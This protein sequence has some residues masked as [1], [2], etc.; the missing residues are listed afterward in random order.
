MRATRLVLMLLAT[1]AMPR[2]FGYAFA[3]GVLEI[4]EGT[5]SK[6]KLVWAADGSV[7]NGIVSYYRHT[8]ILPV[9]PVKA[10][11]D[12]YLDDDGTVYVNGTQ[13]ERAGDVAS[14]LHAGT[15]TIAICLV[16]DFY[17]SAAIYMVSCEDASGTR[18]Y[19]HSGPAVR[20]TVKEPKAGWERPDFNDSAWPRVKIC[21][22][23]LGKPWSLN[24][25]L[26]RRF[27]TPEEYASLME[28]E[29]STRVLPEGL[30]S[31]PDP[32]ARVL[33]RG[34]Q[35]KIEI[36]G[37]MYD[38]VVNR[39][40]PG[41]AY[42]DSA[43]VRFGEAGFKIVELDLGMENFYNGDGEPCIFTEVDNAVRRVLSLNPGA[44]LMLGLRFGMREWAMRNPTEQVGYATGPADPKSDDDR[45]GRP[46][47]PSMASDKFRE[48][49]LQMIRELAE[50]VNKQ[51]W[52]KRVIG[53]RPMCG[54]YGEWHCYG[55]FEAP[56]TGLRMQE[57]FRAYMQ[58]KRGIS[59]AKIPT[60]A[61]RRHD[62]CDLLDPAEDRLVLDYYDCHANVTADLLLAIAGE[63]RR[64]FPGRLVGAFYG[65]LFT[66]DAP[67]GTNVLLDKVLSSPDIDFLSSP[68]FHAACARLSGASYVPR[69]I[70]SAFRR[71]DKILLVEDDSRFHHIYRW[72]KNSGQ[73]Y[74]TR[75]ERETEMNMRR[76]WLNQ[77]FDCAGIQLYDPMEGVGQRAHAFD[78]PAVFKALEDAKAMMKKAGTPALL[79]GNDVAVVMSPRERLRQDGGDCTSFTRLLY[80]KSF[81]D[82][83]RSG[84]AFDMLTLEDYVA[85]PRKYKKVVFLNAFYLTKEERATL[86]K[87]TRMPGVTA[88]WI[89]P[90]G[91]VTDSGFDDAAM[92]S[93]TGVTAS[94]VARR[95]KIVCRDPEAKPVCGGKAFA[96]KLSGKSKSIIV[97]E[98]PRSPKEYAALLKEAG[99]WMYT[100]PGNYFRRHGDIFMFH[101]GAVGRHTI[102]MPM[103]SGGVRDLFT[104]ERY[105]A[106]EFVLETDGPNTWLLKVER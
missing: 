74:A 17:A 103:M 94:G 84:A 32:V 73:E 43:I 9:K 78:H 41:D 82:L 21:G 10:K 93:L 83:Y 97:P 16:N 13:V 44:Y 40:D 2:V 34:I 67:E 46:V 75:S 106:K 85:N 95:P 42:R 101:T 51:P 61:M 31:E 59:D 8:F 37:S 91:G 86:T 49:S 27:T 87:F 39:C 68:P 66:T 70:P 4:P 63:T 23:V 11:F 33:Y 12:A 20:G 62:G 48:L 98:P 57:K 15:N 89:G 79:S 80:Q 56:D 3:P 53:V 52:S 22:D 102:R 81:L 96:K 76:N 64:L 58:A 5:V 100:A 47:R 7:T 60:A 28:I 88:V 1:L 65:Y 38:A 6:S 24:N 29:A 69:T 92:S 19:I 55:M 45:V 72:I 26:R 30:A 71:F 50:Y 99:A 90:A 54:V 35:P 14:H 77:F 18:C 105:K 25:D 36:N 104:D